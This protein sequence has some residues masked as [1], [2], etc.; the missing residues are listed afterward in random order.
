MEWDRGL[1]NI[2]FMGILLSRRPQ[3]GRT[4][5][6]STMVSRRSQTKVI[7]SRTPFTLP[8]SSECKCWYR[9]I[10]PRIKEHRQEKKN[11]CEKAIL[12]AGKQL[13][14]YPS[15]ISLNWHAGSHETEGSS[16]NYAH[17]FSQTLACCFSDLFTFVHVGMWL[18][19]LQDYCEHWEDGICDSFL[20]PEESES[21]H[22]MCTRE[23]V[24]L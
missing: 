22:L 6:D 11:K 10:K 2:N 16:K 21:T 18:Q 4:W 19:F 5:C 13:K 17:V 15:E 3:Y 8:R 1:S 23:R 24:Q 12:G 14:W 20:P 9:V 7:C